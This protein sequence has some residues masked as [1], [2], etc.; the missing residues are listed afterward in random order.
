MN[1][2]LVNDTSN[3][4]CGS[5]SVIDVIKTAFSQHKIISQPCVVPSINFADWDN[6]D[7]IVV[8]GEGTLHN[9]RPGAVSIMQLLQ[10][11]L[12]AGC[13]ASLVNSIWQNMDTRWKTVTDRLTVWSV[14]DPLSQQYAT[15]YFKR[16]PV[17]YP[18]Y[19][20]FTSVNLQSENRNLTGVGGS[21]NGLLYP[22]WQ[23]F[24]RINIFDSTWN[25]LVNQCAECNLVISGRHHEL[26]ASCKAGVPFVALDSNSWKNHALAYHGNIP[27]FRDIPNTLEEAQNFINTYK[28]QYS[29]IFDWLDTFNL[30][31]VQSHLLTC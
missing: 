26:Y 11:G 10:S 6:I 23:N 13:S 30:E 19:S 21:L 29:K 1:V 16:H 27:V 8:N 28:D 9:N 3:F 15:K 4:H 5:A 14:R 18:D 12:D 24:Q 20:W 17:L 25:D 31:D 7:H 2:L 22:N